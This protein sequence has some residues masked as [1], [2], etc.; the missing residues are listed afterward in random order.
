MNL[1]PL[2]L[3]YLRTLT[4]AERQKFLSYLK[5][6]D[7]NIAAEEDHLEADA[8]FDS[9]NNVLSDNPLGINVVQAILEMDGDAD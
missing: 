9:G 4:P 3:K 8:L 6:A 1:S 2:T 5:D 7:V